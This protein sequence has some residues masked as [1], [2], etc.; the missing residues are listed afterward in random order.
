MAARSQSATLAD[1]VMFR[2]GFN[3]FE[4]FGPAQCASTAR[5]E[6]SHLEVRGASSSGHSGRSRFHVLPR[7][8]SQ[9][10]VEIAVSISS[11]MYFE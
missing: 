11:D 9:A 5:T 3:W 2:V 8:L 7:V 10:T 6:D 1:K 4:P